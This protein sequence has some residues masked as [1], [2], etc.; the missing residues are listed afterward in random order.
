MMMDNMGKLLYMGVGTLLF[1][2]ALVV[3]FHQ[4]GAMK[5]MR[6]T[7]KD[8]YRDSSWMM[9][10]TGEHVNMEGIHRPGIG[11]EDFELAFVMEGHEL[12][13]Y[14]VGVDLY[15]NRELGL[16]KASFE[17]V[18]TYQEKVIWFDDIKRT[19]SDA[20]DMTDER[21]RYVLRAQGQV[22]RIDSR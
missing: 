9:P 22:I 2:G 1:L 14:L 3:F 8:S 7:M 19:F 10:E 20:L 21:K 16:W 12:I 6:D 13:D 15:G 18:D 17:S 4:E 11:E 5:V